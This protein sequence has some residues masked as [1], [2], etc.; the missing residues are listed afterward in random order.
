L[1]AQVLR[2]KGRNIAEAVAKIVAEK[3]ITQVIFGRSAEKGLHRLFYLSAVH[4]F[5]RKAPSVDVH[6]V[7]HA[8]DDRVIG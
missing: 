1:G 3:H 7:T 4:R 8:G 2:T 6:I 5:L